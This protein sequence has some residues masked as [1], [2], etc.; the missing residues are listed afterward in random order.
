MPVILFQAFV[1]KQGIVFCLVLSHFVG[2]LVVE[3]R[4]GFLMICIGWW[5]VHGQCV[6]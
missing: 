2:D 6:S 3:R 4:L 1:R 5:M